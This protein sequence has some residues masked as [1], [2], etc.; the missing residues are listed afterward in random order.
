MALQRWVFMKFQGKGVK[1]MDVLYELFKL[2]DLKYKD[3]NKR[4]IPN[5]DEN[6]IIGIR[7]P[8]L[9]KFAKDFYKNDFEGAISFMENF[10]HFYLEEENLHLFLIENMKNFENV[11]ECFEKILPFIDNWQSCDIFY[12]KIFKK[13]KDKLYKKILEW[14]HSKDVYTVRFAIKLLITDYLDCDFKIEDLKMVSSIRSEN[15]YVNMARAWYF[16]VS[17]LKQ[18]DLSIK[19][20]ENK[21]LDV[22]THNK[23]I[24]KAIESKLID[25]DKKKYLKTLKIK[26]E[27]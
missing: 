22:F 20:I 17:L 6:R 25:F 1:F 3:F 24:Q 2:Q 8:I 14:I 23:T 11:I 18:Y 12:P 10:S 26:K 15:Y 16:Q 4:L 21:V 13:N 7:V 5:I 9:R 19:F 27:I